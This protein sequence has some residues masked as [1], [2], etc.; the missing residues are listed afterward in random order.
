MT[1]STRTTSRYKSWQVTAEGCNLVDVK[2]ESDLAEDTT[3][4]APLCPLERLVA[5]VFLPCG[6]RAR[7]RG[8]KITASCKAVPLR[9]SD[10]LEASRKVPVN[11]KIELEGY[12]T[13]AFTW[14]QEEIERE[15]VT[16]DWILVPV[17]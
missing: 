17:R 14:I 12:E 5:S 2:I 16:P 1:G 9:S 13:L 6:D 10:P 4:V 15:E 3:F 11:V 8:A 7:D